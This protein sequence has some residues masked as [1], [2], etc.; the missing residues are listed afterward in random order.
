MRKTL[1]ILTGAALAL[2][3]CGSGKEPETQASEQSLD[4]A[5][6][7]ATDVAPSDPMGAETGIPAPAPSSGAGS[8]SVKP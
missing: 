6:N 2:A 5:V 1:I 8:A 7:L 4:D 3:A